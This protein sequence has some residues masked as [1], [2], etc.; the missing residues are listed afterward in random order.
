MGSRVA[1]TWV[2]AVGIARADGFRQPRYLFPPQDWTDVVNASE[3]W[4][5]F[6]LGEEVG[7][8]GTFLFNGLKRL[9]EITSLKNADDVFE[10]LYALSVGTERILKVAVVLLEHGDRT[11]QAEFEK[12][13]VT[14]EHLDLLARVRAKVDINLHC[15][16]NEFLALLGQF[17]AT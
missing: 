5:N 16:H 2:K 8:A 7:I 11:D 14:H 15:V 17:T 13:L 9:H 6:D 10:C 4:R 1:R 3:F 12:S